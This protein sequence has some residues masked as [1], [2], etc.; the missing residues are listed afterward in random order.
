MGRSPCRCRPRTDLARVGHLARAAGVSPLPLTTRQCE[1]LR[2]RVDVAAHEEEAD[3]GSDPQR[4]PWVE[5][6]RHRQV[7]GSER[8][9]KGA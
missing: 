2:G 9:L 6:G 3:E 7:Y 5:E 8:S 1:V 4:R